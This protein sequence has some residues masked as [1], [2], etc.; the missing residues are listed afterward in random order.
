[1]QRFAI[2]A[3]AIMACI[4][5]SADADT[6]PVDCELTVQGRTYIKGVCQFSA[7]ADGSF[8]IFGK[9]YFAYV[10]VVSPGVAEASW[11]ADPASTHAQAPLGELRQSGGC[12]VGKTVKICARALSPA[13][14]KAAIA[15]QPNGL[16]LFPEMA[17]QSCIGVEGPVEPGADLVLRNCRVPSDLI[18]VR[19]QDG[20]L[21]VAKA[22][23]LCLGLKSPDTSQPSRLAL[24]KCQ[25]GSP[26]W[27]T[28]ATSTVAA[29]VQSG[30]GLCLSIP[31]MAVPDARFPF[32]VQAAP[33][34]DESRALK[35]ILSKG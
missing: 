17:L 27:T 35:F 29:P 18:F 15:S 3:A 4:T 26:R 2:V 22:P 14:E 10:N 5:T 1:V 20:S 7:A 6:R 21:G 23:D 19:R 31:Q 11:N 34:T 32:V 25:S 13:A 28:V 9:D 24:E 33:C 16:A 12:W 8:Q 30:A